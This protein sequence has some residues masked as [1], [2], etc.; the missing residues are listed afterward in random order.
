MNEKTV[1]I[2]NQINK[3]FYL[4]TQEHFSRTRQYYWRGWEKLL[5]HLQ[6]STLKVLDIGCGNGRFGQ[7]LLEK[8][9]KVKIE[10]TGVDNNQFLLNQAKKAVNK[11][12]FIKQDILD[13]WKL[14]KSKFNL[15]IM[16]GILH[17][18]PG[19]EDRKELLGKAKTL[20]EKNGLLIFTIWQFKHLKRFQ[21]KIIPWLEFK[22]LTSSNIDLSQL[23]K[24]DYILGWEKGGRAYRYCHFINNDELNE[25]INELEMK[26]IKIFESDAK[27]GR[28]NKYILLRK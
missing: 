6:E 9:P 15:V 1:K 28:G 26:V 5:P 23:E 27:E 3:K 21:K 7:F 12:K 11:G 10:Y 22:E 2:L 8:L 16:L 19:R 13:K 14:E 24:N 25:I 17:H 20:L 18:L 4:T